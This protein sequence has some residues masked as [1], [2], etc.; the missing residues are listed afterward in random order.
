[1][2]KARHI[3]R[4]YAGSW[5][6]DPTDLSRDGVRG[7]TI[8]LKS[9]LNPASAGALQNTKQ[10]GRNPAAPENAARGTY[11]MFKI[12]STSFGAYLAQTYEECEMNR[13]SRTS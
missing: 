13:Q 12:G 1:M 10:R 11:I 6:R 2:E 7:T 5:G 4:M 8:E 9:M 3:R